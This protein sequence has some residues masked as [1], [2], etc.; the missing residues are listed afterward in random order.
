M[1]RICQILCQMKNI[2]WNGTI[3]QG[4]VNSK[5]KMSEHYDILTFLLVRKILTKQQRLFLFCRRRLKIFNRLCLSVVNLFL[6]FT[7]LCFC[8]ILMLRNNENR[9]KA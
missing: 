6:D 7:F 3:L 8:G 1:G 2:D 4:K 9:K 5:K